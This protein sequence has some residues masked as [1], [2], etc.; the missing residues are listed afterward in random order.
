MITNCQA[1]IFININ[2]I[3]KKVIT[4]LLKELHEMA[5]DNQTQKNETYTAFV[6]MHKRIEALVKSHMSNPES[7][8]VAQ[9]AFQEWQSAVSSVKGSGEIQ[10]ADVSNISKLLTKGASIIQYYGLE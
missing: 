8:P 5:F 6:K 1:F 4:M 7:K 3:F 9:K 10:D 2:T